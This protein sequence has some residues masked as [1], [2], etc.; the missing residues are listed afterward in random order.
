MPSTTVS[1]VA[2]YLRH[3]N[4]QILLLSRDW[5]RWDGPDSCATLHMPGC[6]NPMVQSEWFDPT[7]A[8][9]PLLTKAPLPN[10]PLC[11]DCCRRAVRG[12]S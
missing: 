8:N 4:P 5:F 3:H 9:P 10:R 7:R 12:D 2:V 11:V 1:D 6:R